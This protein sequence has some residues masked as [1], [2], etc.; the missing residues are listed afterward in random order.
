MRYLICKIDQNLLQLLAQENVF[1]SVVHNDRQLKGL[2]CVTASMTLSMR[3][4]KHKNTLI[5]VPIC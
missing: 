4:I 5:I 1:K 3:D 2:T